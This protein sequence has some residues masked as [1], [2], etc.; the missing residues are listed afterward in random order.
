MSNVFE[1]VRKACKWGALPQPDDAFALDD[2]R[3]TL[4]QLVHEVSLRTKPDGRTVVASCDAP[5]SETPP[6]P[7]FSWSR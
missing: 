1:D 6:F 7:S 5:F 2:H 3:R 4:A